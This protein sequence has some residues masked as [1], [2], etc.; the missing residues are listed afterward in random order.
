MPRV[1]REYKLPAEHEFELELPTG[2]VVV[3]V[4]IRNG[5]NKDE[6]KVEENPVLY[7]KLD[8]EQEPLITRKYRLYATSSPIGDL[9]MYVGTFMFNRRQHAWHLFEVFEELE[10]TSSEP[11]DS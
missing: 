3:F 10:R 5:F 2:A 9:E 6:S 1:I 4:T 8:D 7:I 11:Q